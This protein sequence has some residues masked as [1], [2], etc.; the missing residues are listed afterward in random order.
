MRVAFVM[1]DTPHRRD[2]PA[3]HRL[4]RLARGLADRDHDSIV[5]CVK[6]WDGDH[7]TFEQNGVEYRAVTDSPSIRSFATKLPFALRKVRPDV[8]HATNSP[9]AQVRAANAASPFLRT[10]VVVDW[11]TDVDGDTEHAY[12]SAVHGAEAIVTPSR[13]VKTIV[14]EH[15]ANAEAIRVIPESLDFETVRRVE[16]HPIADLV[17]SRRLDRHANVETFLLAL[18]ELRGHE[19]TAA[20]IGDGPARV[21]AERTAADLRIDGRV[22]FLGEQPFEDRVAIMKGAR[23]FA[24]TAEFEPFASELLV[25][26]A[27]GCVGIAEYQVASAAHELIEGKSRL[28]GTH[29]S[30]VTSPQE[31]A[32]AVIEAASMEQRTLN[33]AYEL[34]DH[35]AIFDRYVECYRDVQSTAGLF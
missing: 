34:Y 35:D 25:A 33:E 31:F 26:L 16:P 27:C 24:Q 11:W 21:D 10:P 1:M 20:V 17:Y 30:L 29:G 28:E 32:E 9:P 4:H 23:I 18:A 2:T 14:R 22:R 8:I 6:W 19:W 7:S 15:G 12:E 13:F 3:V 5:L